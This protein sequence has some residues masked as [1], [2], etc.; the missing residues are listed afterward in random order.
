[1]LALY[2]IIIQKRSYGV[3]VCL[4]NMI[5]KQSTDVYEYNFYGR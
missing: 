4:K 3:C 5:D 2:M 1:M